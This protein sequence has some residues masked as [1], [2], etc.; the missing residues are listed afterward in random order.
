[1]LDGVPLLF[2]NQDHRRH[3]S[4]ASCVHGTEQYDSRIAPDAGEGRL[5]NAKMAERSFYT[6]NNTQTIQ[7]GI[8]L[9]TWQGQATRQHWTDGQ[10]PPSPMSI[11][12]LKTAQKNDGLPLSQDYS[13]SGWDGFVPIR[14]QLSK[15]R[16]S[17]LY[18]G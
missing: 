13:S 17:W 2:M 16:S 14:R 12:I 6:Q 4:Q 11:W 7:M 9:P 5:K 8:G 15:Q 18:L 10:T 3:K 1:M